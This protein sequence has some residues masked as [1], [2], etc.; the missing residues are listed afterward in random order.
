MTIRSISGL[1]LGKT[2]FCIS[3][4]E[5]DVFSSAGFFLFG[6]STENKSVDFSI[7]V[8][9]IGVSTIGVGVE[10]GGLFSG[11]DF[12]KVPFPFKT[13]YKSTS[14]KTSKIL[15]MK[16]RLGL[17]LPES[18]WDKLERCTPILSANEEAFE[19][20]IIQQDF[21]SF[22]KIFRVYHCKFV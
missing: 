8:S 13:Q 5:L 7:L 18:K 14:G 17:F 1:F 10:K 3:G 9:T 15:S 20:V 11:S 2:K 12:G 4:M 21:Q 6:I 19:T 16:S 22:Y